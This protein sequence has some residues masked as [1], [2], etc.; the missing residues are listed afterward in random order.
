MQMIVLLIA[1]YLIYSVLHNRSHLLA[2]SIWSYL[3]AIVIYHLH[4]SDQCITQALMVE[5]VE[6]IYHLSK[7]R[8]MLF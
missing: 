6:M 8:S 5:A 2:D 3:Q 4:C 1:V 7:R